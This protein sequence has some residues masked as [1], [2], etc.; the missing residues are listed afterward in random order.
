MNKFTI[1]QLEYLVA[2]GQYGNLTEAAHHLRVSQPAI[3]SAIAHLEGVLGQQLFHRHRGSGVSPTAAG[4]RALAEA[5]NILTLVDDFPGALNVE[6]EE[7]SGTVLLS[8]FEPLACYQLPAM[9]GAMAAEFPNIRIEFSLQTQS[10]IHEGLQTGE[11]E[12]GF[13]YDTGFWKDLKKVVLYHVTP[14]ALLPANHR[15]ARQEA[16][17]I[18]DLVREPFVLVDLPES[19]EYQLSLMRSFGAEPQVRYYCSN[20]EVIRGLVANGL[21]VS[22]SVTRPVGDRCYDGSRLAYRPLA[23]DVP[24]QAVV[25]AYSKGVRLTRAAKLVLEGIRRYFHSQTE[26]TSPDV[27]VPLPV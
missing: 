1:R 22:L 21:G 20:L 26:R 6:A 16:V 2:V 19:R 10:R 12:L 15:L 3:T 27:Q 13:S 18:A 8:C 11:F 7:M 25:L 14:Y 5:R 9:L 4:H 23:E 17:S 24:M